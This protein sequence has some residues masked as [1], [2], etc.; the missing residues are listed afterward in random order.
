MDHTDRPNDQFQTVAPARKLLF[1]IKAK[2]KS[3]TGFESFLRNRGWDVVATS[4][5]KLA[6]SALF[7][8]PVHCVLITVEHSNPS[9][10]KIPGILAQTSKIPF[11]LF[12]EGLTPGGTNILRGSEHPYILAA[13]VS[14]PAIER[15][16]LRI[17][18]EIATASGATGSSALS[19]DENVTIIQREPNDSEKEEHVHL[20]GEPSGPKG[21]KEF[22]RFEP[23]ENGSVLDRAA[24]KA[25]KEASVFSTE[26][27]GTLRMLDRKARVCCVHVES[28]LFVG[29]LVVA[30]A[31][32]RDD[33]SEFMQ[34]FKT[35]LMGHLNDEGVTT[36]I[37]EVPEFC[38]NEVSF[39]EWSV[40]E[41]AFLRK[42]VHHNG[43]IGVS[44]FRHNLVTQPLRE[45][46]DITMSRIGLQEIRE[47][48][49]LAFDVYIYLPVNK[50]YIRYAA[51]E[52]FLYDT[53]R[54]RL[55]AG[56]VEDVHIKRESEKDVARYR[57]Q[58]EL[59]DKLRS[60]AGKKSA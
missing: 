57:L 10:M 55:N 25:L 6:L 28:G 41:A 43:E 2:E 4:D 50:K 38:L 59:N 47:D 13:P 45:S 17:E 24:T 16:V 21:I 35:L 19:R 29:V 48:V 27:D 26:T 8:R 22:S 53:Q 5:I 60:Y 44:F 54:E 15:M 56:G 14:G 58:I 23:K 18:K 39:E 37:V 1:V 12:S 7:D 36:S 49:A 33:G 34:N 46:E 9:C 30:F 51:K 20:R 42:S 32:D 40:A 31:T 52:R 3:S 11:I